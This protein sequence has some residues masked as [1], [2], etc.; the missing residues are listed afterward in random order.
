MAD[1]ES[2]SSS[3]R[4]LRFPVFSAKL[5]IKPP[6]LCASQLPLFLVTYPLDDSLNSV[7]SARITV[8]I[9]GESRIFLRVSVKFSRIISRLQDEKLRR[10]RTEAGSQNRS[11]QLFSLATRFRQQTTNFHEL[12]LVSF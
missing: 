9:T 6:A 10:V 3:T 2:S 4:P 5:E 11:L 7:G 12:L 8:R 1:E